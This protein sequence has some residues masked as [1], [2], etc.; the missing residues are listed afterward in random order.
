LDKAQKTIE[1]MNDGQEQIHENIIQSPQEQSNLIETKNLFGDTGIPGLNG[2]QS[3]PFTDAQTL[4]RE[5]IGQKKIKTLAEVDALRK[6]AIAKTKAM[7]DKDAKRRQK[8]HE[9]RKPDKRGMPTMCPRCGV[10]NQ[11]MIKN[12]RQA[13]VTG[14]LVKKYKC[15][16]CRLSFTTLSKVYLDWK[17]KQKAVKKRHLAALKAHET[18]RLN[19]KL[20][21]I[22]TSKN[23]MSNK[24]QKKKDK[25]DKKAAGNTKTKK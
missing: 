17:E 11:R 9:G 21:N 5:R 15:L 4:L 14:D 7:R 13:C 22:H 10:S 19:S 23:N 8:I 1:E 18:R 3:G 16:D 24:S 6:E 20:N 2:L 12:G 25:K